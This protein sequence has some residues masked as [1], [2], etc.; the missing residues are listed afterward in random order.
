M[1]PRVAVV[2]DEARMAEMIAMV[3]APLEVEVSTFPGP[4]RFLAAAAESPFDVVLSDLRMP[5]MDGVELLRRYRS[6]GGDGPV[7]LVTAHASV[8]TA[9][10]A[11]KEGAF[12]YV[13]KPFVNDDVRALVRRA[14]DFTRLERENRALRQELRDRFGTSGFLATGRRMTEVLDL[15]RRAARSRSSVLVTGESGTGK[16]L[17]ARAVHY[18][19]DRIGRPFV[20]VNCKALASGVL[21]SELFGHAR[22]AFTGATADRPG[23]FE[24]ADGGTLFLDEIG[25]VDLSFQAKLLRVVQEREVQRV[26]DDAVRPV[27]VRIVTATHRDLAAEVAAGRFREDLYFRLAVIPI[28]LPPLRD[29][30]EDV[31]PMARHFLEAQNR[32]LGRSIAGWTPE[33]ESWLLS[34]AWPGNVRELHNAIERAAVLAR[35]DVLTLEDVVPRGAAAPAARE[36]TLHEY[37]DRMT[38]ERLRTVLVESDGLRIEAARCLGIERTTLYRLMKKFG[39]D[40]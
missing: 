35:E 38:A 1:R 15:V 14:L 18:Y 12:D 8:A 6:A 28:S 27:D 17:V 39:I 19:S 4:S 23:L 30:R 7:V 26:G 5:E 3:L 10:A 16:E 33:V 2:D 20:A 11:M 34:H 9:I 36:E 24:R 25:D 13:E 29:R 37:L 32:E 40:G 21:E 22:G 31:L